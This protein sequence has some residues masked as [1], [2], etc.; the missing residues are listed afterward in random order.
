[1]L[2]FTAAGISQVLREWLSGGCKE[3]PE[4]MRQIIVQNIPTGVRQYVL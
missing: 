3:P 4:Q 2:I 1:M